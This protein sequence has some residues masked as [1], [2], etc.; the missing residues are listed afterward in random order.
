MGRDYSPMRAVALDQNA[1]AKAHL[2]RRRG[3]FCRSGQLLKNQP[4]ESPGSTH[5]S[6]LI[7]LGMRWECWIFRPQPAQA[8]GFA[9]PAESKPEPNPNQPYPLLLNSLASRG[10]PVDT[11]PRLPG[12]SPPSQ[13]KRLWKGPAK[14]RAMSSSHQ[15]H[16]SLITGNLASRCLTI[17]FVS[18]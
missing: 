16:H 17:S 2:C 14:K 18:H 13:L 4:F 3:R 7:A 6:V 12:G 15:E 9:I 10:V 1:V 5:H 11:R 8:T